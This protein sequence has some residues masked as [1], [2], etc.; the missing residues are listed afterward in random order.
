M[1]LVALPLDV[2][3]NIMMGIEDVANITDRLIDFCVGVVRIGLVWLGRSVPYSSLTVLIH[4]SLLARI[5]KVVASQTHHEVLSVAL[6][7]SQ[8]TRVVAS[9]SSARTR[10]SVAIR[11]GRVGRRWVITELVNLHLGCFKQ[12]LDLGDLRCLLEPVQLMS[13]HG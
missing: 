4:S 13:G 8:P 12:R 10:L 2:V 7:A 5:D 6:L 11:H 1:A 9:P 3:A